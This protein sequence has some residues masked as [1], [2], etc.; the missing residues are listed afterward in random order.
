MSLKVQGFKFQANL[1]V[2]TFDEFDA[3]LGMDWLTI[4]DA[5]I[6]YKIKKFSLKSSDDTLV[7]Y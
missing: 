1:M 6:D 3:I 2:L 7:R 4:H 5:T